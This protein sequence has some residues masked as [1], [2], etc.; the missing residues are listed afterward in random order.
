LTYW[1]DCAPP[2][3]SWKLKRSLG[4]FF[5]DGKGLI[6][7]LAVP[8][9]RGVDLVLAVPGLGLANF[10]ILDALTSYLADK[11]EM[12]GEFEILFETDKKNTTTPSTVLH[13]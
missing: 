10:I 12:G 11:N 1:L 3:N 8:G 7:T 5:D 6:S 9:L 13:L 2:I 4:F